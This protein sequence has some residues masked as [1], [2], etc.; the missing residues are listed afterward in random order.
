MLVV[1]TNVMPVKMAAALLYFLLCAMAIC[2]PIRVLNVER[3]I[4]DCLDPWLDQDPRQ[5]IERDSQED[6]DGQRW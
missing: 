3:I 5:Q 4:Q 1:C 2:F 6:G